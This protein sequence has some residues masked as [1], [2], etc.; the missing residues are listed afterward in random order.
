MQLSE[1]STDLINDIQNRVLNMNILFYGFSFDEVFDLLTE[2]FMNDDIMREE[3][4]F[5]TMSMG[6]DTSEIKFKNLMDAGF[7]EDFSR[8]ISG[9]LIPLDTNEIKLL[10]TSTSKQDL[11]TKLSRTRPF[12]SLWVKSL[13]YMVANTKYVI[14][15]LEDI[16][17]SEELISKYLLF[18]SR[19]PKTDMSNITD[20]PKGE[21]SSTRLFYSDN[22]ILMA[23]D[24]LNKIVEIHQDSF[25]PVVR[26]GFGM[27][28]GTYTKEN[29]S[30]E[31]FCG[32]FYYYEGDSDIMI[33]AKNILVCPNK[34]CALTYF[35]GKDSVIELLNANLDKQGNIIYV[36]PKLSVLQYNKLRQQIEFTPI[37]CNYI[38]DNSYL[39][40]DLVIDD[41]M[42]G[43]FD[44]LKHYEGMFA[45]EDRFDQ[46][47]CRTISNR[48]D[49]VILTTMTGQERVVSEILDPR[50]RD[51][52]FKKLVRLD[53][54][55][56]LTIKGKF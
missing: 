49:L 8:Q 26:Y 46:V 31:S 25:F 43:R 27:S 51:I 34:I 6:N 39:S 50:E 11:L 23:D 45:L 32:T 52:S 37:K 56:I 12:L 29:N 42:T 16:G 9:A 21:L 18:K 13:D 47:L 3:F 36:D 22:P 55:T 30:N 2:R 48:F 1:L 14:R 20:I 4:S 10:N 15:R 28:K 7:D 33:Q 24:W 19:R 41:M 40:W 38:F 35:L 54:D 53:Y 5:L 17:L 44:F